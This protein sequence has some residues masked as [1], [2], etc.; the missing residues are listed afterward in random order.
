MNILD[1]IANRFGYQKLAEAQQKPEQK[2]QKR[3]LSR[4]MSGGFKGGDTGR[5]FADWSV[6]NVSLN[7]FIRRD[8][9]K[10]RVRSRDLCINDDYGKKFIGLCERNIVGPNGIALSMDIKAEDETRDRK[11]CVEVEDPWKEWCED[12]TVTGDM[13]WIDVQNLIATTTPQDGEYVVRIVRG[14][15]NKSGFALQLIPAEALDEEKFD[16]LPNGHTIR[17][18]VE[19]DQW[20]RR[21]AYWIRVNDP[22]DFYWGG[23]TYSSTRIPAEE[24]IHDFARMGINQVRGF[25]WFHASMVGLKHLGAY[26]EAALVAARAGAGKMGFYKRMPDAAGNYSGDGEDAEGNILQDMEPGALEVLP[27]GY[28]MQFNDPAY[29][30]SD[31]GPFVQA[32]LMGVSAGLGV[33]YTSLSGNLSAVNY[34][35]IRAGL[36]DERDMWMGAQGWYIRHLHKPVFRPWLEMQLLTRTIR[37]PEAQ[38]DYLNKPRW[39]GRRWAWVDPEKDVTATIMAIE[40]GLFTRSKALRD[41]GVGDLE[42]VFRELEHEEELAD[43]KNLNFSRH[44]EAELAA[45]ANPRGRSSPE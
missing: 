41:S 30:H 23:Q 34:S 13:T 9:L 25:P 20:K 44:T 19:R 5:L 27:T 42:D 3:S 2:Q 26:Q 15:P 14:Y 6:A 12:C 18:G 31:H 21:V 11:A 10:C 38:F 33:S 8:L 29:P 7:E 32:V 39:N 16:N 4:S 40:S 17:M 43:K 35:S 24:I 22:T 36:L 37:R 45:A 1:R 28:E